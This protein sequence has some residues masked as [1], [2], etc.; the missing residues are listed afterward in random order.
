MA[1][2]PRMNAVDTGAG[3]RGDFARAVWAATGRV[4]ESAKGAGSAIEQG[5]RAPAEGPAGR[6]LT[7]SLRQQS[8]DEPLGNDKLDDARSGAHELVG[9][10][11]EFVNKRG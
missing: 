9:E 2:I 8:D 11:E 5:V 6:G 4:E 1:D 10:V 7:D 3:D